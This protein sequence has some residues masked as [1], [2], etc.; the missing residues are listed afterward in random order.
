MP[1]ADRIEAS[2]I[3]HIPVALFNKIVSE[4]PPPSVNNQTTELHAGF[5]LGV[6]AAIQAFKEHVK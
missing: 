3:A 5:L 6:Q 1:S 2:Y 4:L